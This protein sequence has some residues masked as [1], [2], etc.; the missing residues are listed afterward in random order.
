MT[1]AVLGTHLLARASVTRLGAVCLRGRSVWT[2]TMRVLVTIVSK[3]EVA[4]AK[5]SIGID[6]MWYVARK[7]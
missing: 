5:L 1:N 6:H 2:A 3:A 7:T 4:K